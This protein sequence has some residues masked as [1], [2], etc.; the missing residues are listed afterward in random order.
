MTVGVGVVGA[1][2]LGEAEG[3]VVV[4]VPAVGATVVLVPSYS[5]GGAV[6]CVAVVGTIEG[7][8]PGGTVGPTPPVGGMVGVPEALEAPV[9]QITACWFLENAHRTP[10]F[11][12]VVLGP[13][14]KVVSKAGWVLSLELTQPVEVQTRDLAI[15]HPRLGMLPAIISCWVGRRPF[16]WAHIVDA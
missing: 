5:E 14:P 10:R 3:A 4:V 8:A 9:M 12:R 11:A 15:P 7:N 16:C 1:A 6:G 2:E 13:V